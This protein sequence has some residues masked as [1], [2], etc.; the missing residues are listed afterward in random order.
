M[1]KEQ[2]LKRVL[3]KIGKE[4][5]DRLKIAIT[6]P[7]NGKPLNASSRLKNTI[8]LSMLWMLKKD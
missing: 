5:I 4:A 3:D 6:T 2:L 7:I 8:W 1:N